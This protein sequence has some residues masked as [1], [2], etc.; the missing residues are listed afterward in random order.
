MPLQIP[1]FADRMY[2]YTIGDFTGHGQHPRV[3]GGD[4]HFRI[5]RIDG[6]RT[7]LRCDEGELVEVAVMIEGAGAEGG[8]AGR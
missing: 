6:S 8:E 4:V 5:G 3:H 1:G 7:P 2:V